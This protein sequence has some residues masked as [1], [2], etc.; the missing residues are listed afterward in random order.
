VNGEKIIKC[1]P[2]FG[3]DYDKDCTS[4]D[5]AENYQKLIWVI[6]VIRD[7][8]NLQGYPFSIADVEMALFMMGK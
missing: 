7:E 4:Q 5:W 6:E 8:L 3:R 2:G 1:P